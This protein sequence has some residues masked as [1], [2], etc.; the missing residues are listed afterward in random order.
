VKDVRNVDCVRFLGLRGLMDRYNLDSQGLV[1]DVQRFCVHDGP[2]IRTTVFLKGCPLDCRWC[3]NPESKTSYP[4]LMVHDIRCIRCGRCIEECPQQAIKLGKSIRINRR[5][6]DLCLKCVHIC[7]SG[8]I[9]VAGQLMTVE[10][11]L[12]EIKKDHLLYRNS[13]GGVTVSGGEP[14]LQ[15]RFVRNLLKECHQHGFHTALDTSGY[16]PWNILCKVLEYTDLCLYD[17]K[18]VEAENHVKGTGKS[19]R[20]I[21]E[22]LFLSTSQVLTW[23]RVPLI[24]GYN[25][26]R[27]NIMNMIEIAK[28]ADVEKISF[29]PYH[30]YGKTKYVS[31]GRRYG[32]G[33]LKPPS[34]AD[35][36]K[37]VKLVRNAGIKVTIG[38]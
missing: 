3:S 1:F 4:D 34:N 28:K 8:A 13:N 22:N 38:H 14:L 23:L 2:G 12:F 33:K 20:R 24:P 11:V 25:D 29:L 10:E 31:L 27:A 19:N 37:L 17:L 9:T 15:W 26:S 5:S 36:Q 30:E 35:L 6:C 32:L 18:H 16:A 7:P 21:L